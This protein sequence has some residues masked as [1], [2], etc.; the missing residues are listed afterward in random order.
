M[1][2]FGAMLSAFKTQPPTRAQ[3]LAQERAAQAQVTERRGRLN[4]VS[5]V[6]KP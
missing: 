2:F 5:S 6:K 3:Q 4:N 1:S